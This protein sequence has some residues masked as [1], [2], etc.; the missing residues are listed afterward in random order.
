[1]LRS[2]YS[3]AGQSPTLVEIAGKI[4]SRF[5][6]KLDMISGGNSSSIYLIDKDGLPE[7]IN[8]LR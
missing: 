6:I 2:R 7:G 4:E 1:M 5:N 8:S 3:K